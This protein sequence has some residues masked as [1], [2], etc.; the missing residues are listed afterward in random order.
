[1]SPGNSVRC[2]YTKFLWFMLCT[3]WRH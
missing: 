1:M 3:T 2:M